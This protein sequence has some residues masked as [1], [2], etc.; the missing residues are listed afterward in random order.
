LDRVDLLV[1][2]QK[3]NDPL[4][5]R[6][7]T[8]YRLACTRRFD[9]L[10][11]FGV[12][13][14][15]RSNKKYNL[16]VA[17]VTLEIEHTTLDIGG[18]VD[19]DDLRKPIPVDQA[20]SRTNRLLVRGAAGSGKTTLLQWAAVYCAARKHE[21]ALATFNDLVPFVIRLRDFDDRNL[22][23]P[24]E[25]ARVVAPNIEG[26]PDYWSHR[27]LESGRAIVLIDGLDEAAENRRAVVREWLQDLLLQYPQAQYLVT[28]RPYAVK[29]G[30]LDSDGFLDATLQEMTTEDVAR[31]VAHWHQA[32]ATGL[33]DQEERSK[34]TKLATALATELRRNPDLSKLAASPLLCAMIC[35]LHR[36][37][38]SALPTGRIE[39]YHACV[40]M[41]FRRDEE[42]R[43][44]MSDY[45]QLTQPQKLIL[46]RYFAW[47]LIRNGK[48]SA[49][50][51]ETYE[52]L[53]HVLAEL[54][55]CP[56]EAT[57]AAVARLFI[58]RVAILRQFATGKID[59]TH[60]TFQEFLA[61]QE[62]LVE[63]DQQLLI[64]HAEKEQ[65]REV[66]ILA[67]GLIDNKTKAEQFVLGLLG[68]GDKERK[69]TLYVIAAAALQLVPRLPD[70][71]SVKSEVRNRLAEIIPPNSMT[72]AQ[73]LAD[74]GNLVVPLLKYDRTRRANETAASLRTLAL[75]N[76]PE[77]HSAL[78]A[79]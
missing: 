9:H 11:L 54:N 25:F 72:D 39:L 27:V 3:G 30:W 58:H 31:F 52:R 19:G 69:R 17:Y 7:E 28:T 15:D 2:A 12:D 77:A 55:N 8:N 20:L 37:R 14:S 24:G 71:S 48:S 1:A 33:E 75:V 50:P 78:A 57:G 62:A 73:A 45:V 51:D 4:A 16:S 53:Q 35:A 41:F 6:F 13:V 42:R 10:E 46:L 47:W 76:T 23:R 60:R 61:A 29:E 59:F 56:P 74:A 40:D 66:A 79:R 38:V 64:N 18:E 5:E 26:E 22:P 68:R 70:G 65:C 63:G 67:A 21:G 32:V 34:L 49:T 36:D 43:V 44:Q